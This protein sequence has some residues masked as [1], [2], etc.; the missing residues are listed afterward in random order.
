MFYFIVKLIYLN[1]K[2]NVTKLHD[3]RVKSLDARYM[4]NNVCTSNSTAAVLD[5][6]FQG[7]ESV[8]CKRNVIVSI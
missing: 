2:L 8:F 3:S 5:N 1:L 4:T 7:W 6:L